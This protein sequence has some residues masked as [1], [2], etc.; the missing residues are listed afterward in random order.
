MEVNLE[1]SRARVSTLAYFH[2]RHAR[3]TSLRLSL[4]GMSQEGTQ[5]TTIA[6]HA[7]AQAATLSLS[8]DGGVADKAGLPRLAA[9]AAAAGAS[10]PPLRAPP[11]K[12]L[13][14]YSVPPSCR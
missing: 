2:S 5:I 4:P 11:P 8:D 6:S 1:N 14:S 12:E 9:A 13:A 3:Q 10:S 7:A